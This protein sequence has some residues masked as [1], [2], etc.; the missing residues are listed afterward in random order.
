M[1]Y[2][3]S[4]GTLSLYTTTTVRTCCLEQLCTATIAVV[5]LCACNQLPELVPNRKVRIV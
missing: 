4:S 5:E 3:V 2:N 1:T